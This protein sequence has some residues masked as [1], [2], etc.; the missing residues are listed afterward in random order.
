M[1]A[2]K[3][4][5]DVY[6]NLIDIN[7]VFK[8]VD[9]YVIL[10]MPDHFPNYFDYD[11]IDILCGNRQAFLEHLL[12]VGKPYEKKGFRIDVRITNGHLHV[13]FYPPMAQRLNL[14]FDLV[15]SL[16]LYRNIIVDDAYADVV[17]G[18]RSA[19]TREGGVFQVPSPPHDLAIRFMEYME[20]KDLRPEKVK[21]LEYVKRARSL[22]FV[23][24]V[25]RYT[26]LSLV[27]EPDHGSRLKEGEVLFSRGET[28][29][30]EACFREITAS[31]PRNKE[32]CNNLGVI[33][34]QKGD[35]EGA[36]GYFYQS[37]QA[38]PYYRDAV[39]NLAGV[40]RNLDRLPELL[41]HLENI[42]GRF[43]NDEEM[44]ALRE[45]ARRD[46]ALKGGV[47]DPSRLDYFIIWGHGLKY[48][49]EILDTI[50]NHPGLDIITIRKYRV[51]N[52]AE[53]VRR[54]YESDTV[55]FHHLVNKTR[56]LLGVPPEI[57]VIL[58]MNWAP[59]EKFF[60]SGAFRHIQCEVIKELKETIRN[61]FNPRINGKRTEDHV[62]H[63]SDYESQVEHLLGL[64]NL[65]RIDYFK[66]KPNRFLH[67]PYHIQPFREFMIKEI[68]IS[69]IC[70]NILEGDADR[71]HL[72]PCP[73]EESPHYRYLEGNPLPYVE[74]METFGGVVLT[75]DH[76]VQEFERLAKEFD[77]LVP[78]H[79]NDYIL[80]KEEG[81]GRYAV[82]D[83]VHRLAILRHRRWERVVAAVV[84]YAADVKPADR[85]GLNHMAEKTAGKD[86]IPFPDAGPMRGVRPSPGVFSGD[87][88]DKKT[89]DSL[90]A[91]ETRNREGTKAIACFRK[92]LDMDPLCGETVLSFSRFLESE[93][94]GYLAVPYLFRLL[95]NSPENG[96][97]VRILNNVELFLKRKCWILTYPRSG[98]VFL[99][100]LLHRTGLF[101]DYRGSENGYFMEHFNEIR[102]RR[103]YYPE[104]VYEKW[105][106]SDPGSRREIFFDHV[107]RAHKL[108]PIAKIMRE[109]FVTFLGLKDS[110][111]K[112]I[113]AMLPGMKYIHLRR[114]DIFARTISLYFA[115]KTNRWVLPGE[116]SREYQQVKIPFNKAEI[117]EIYRHEKEFSQKNDWTHYLR[118]GSYLHVDFDRL[119]KN[120]LKTLKE[121]LIYLELDD[122]RLDLEKIVASY[123]YVVTRRE[124]T[125]AYIERLKEIVTQ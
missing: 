125:E 75:D 15:D 70:C 124:E 109:Q 76:L 86:E 7:A 12:R 40:F 31:D 42:T 21:H 80:V 106:N 113:D 114:D 84:D 116:N 115:R 97:V 95:G 53:F 20:W 64:L 101:P 35:L 17:L 52:I 61:R 119:I 107:L 59:R 60:G 71:H 122:P 85:K 121:I 82:M 34:F 28:A 103:H 62:I 1:Q 68:P 8:G 50:R 43:P 98:S 33:A 13:D 63:G 37:L 99:C 26:N 58:V 51:R 45:E 91:A 78:P 38:D 6:S 118:E 16:C 65:G 81:P 111:R 69:R 66:R 39:A 9:D 5:G 123:P 108:P 44:F 94:K 83:G 88:G 24:I 92:S 22:D 117:L 25:N 73:V 72:V 29:A 87:E 18:S 47:N 89:C 36:L 46:A 2:M 48:R 102:L 79:E 27:L 49:D 110:D 11:D 74:Y 112:M 93:N 30:A 90:A 56:Y 10:K 104:A 23:D 105:K 57:L 96:P 100:Y 32:A 67:L 41:P 120:P 4:N 3:N 54:L 77:Y 55:P 19:V 14:R